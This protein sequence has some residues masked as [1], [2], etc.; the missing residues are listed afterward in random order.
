MRK[1]FE[2]VTWTL[3]LLVLFFIDTS[4][5]TLSLCFF[6]FIGLE[7]CFGCG[8]GHAIHY[9]LHLNLSQSYREH[10][11]GTPATLVI[12]YRIIYL[13]F[14]QTKTNGSTTNAFDAAGTTT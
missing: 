1:Y 13:I 3:A 14:I 6:K 11:L 7:S 12:I 4:T 9:T 2:P 5:N 8:I 10:I